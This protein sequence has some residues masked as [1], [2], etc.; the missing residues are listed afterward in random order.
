M[1]LILAIS[2]IHGNINNLKKLL[3]SEACKKS[4]LILVAGDLTNFGDK[5]EIA[6]VIETLNKANK[7]YFYVPGNCDFFNKFSEEQLKCNL[8]SRYVIFLNY[9]II[10]IGGSL[11]TPFNTPFE[12]SEEDFDRILKD[13]Y[14]KVLNENRSG[15]LIVS[16]N[17]PYN[18][19][20]DFTKTGLH[21]G[22]KNLRKFI[23]E[24]KPNLVISG[25]VHEARSIDTINETVLVNPGPLKD[26][27]YAQITIGEKINV[28]LKIL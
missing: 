23:E 17:P 13:V 9:A 14:G 26:G 25:H 6:S 2:D 18:T 10:G 19:K 11:K 21:V 27:F 3:E 24:Y 12:L 15:V 5:K 22:S 16:H 8:H 20:L 4:D 7:P 1:V 28:D